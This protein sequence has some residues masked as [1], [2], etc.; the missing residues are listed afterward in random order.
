MWVKCLAQGHNDG[1]R[2]SE[3]GTTNSLVL[4]RPA[5]PPDLHSL[6]TDTVFLIHFL[7][8]GEGWS[9]GVGFEPQSPGGEVRYYPPP[10]IIG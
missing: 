3:I 10:D 1:L 9:V 6:M 8:H 2:W 4:G 5:L 7:L